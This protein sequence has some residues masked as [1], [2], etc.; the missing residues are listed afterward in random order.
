MKNFDPQL[1]FHQMISIINPNKKPEIKA[2]SS[3][4]SI[5]VDFFAEGGNMVYGLQNNIAFK[6]SEANGKGL[7]AKGFIVSG[8]DTAA[9]FSTEK[10]GMGSFSFIPEKGKK[11]RAIVIYNQ[12]NII[13]DLPV[14][15]DSGW[16]THTTN[17]AGKV[18]VNVACNIPDAHKVHVLILTGNNITNAQSVSLVNGNAVYSIDEANLAD[19]ISQVTVFN[20]RRQPVCE[21]LYFKIP[22]NFLQIKTTGIQYEYA[23]RSKVDFKVFTG[24]NNSYP[25]NAN[26]SASAYLIDS[27]QPQQENNIVSYLWLSTGVKGMIESPSYYFD[28]A[29]ADAAKAADN[30]MLTQGWRRFQWNDVFENTMPA[31]RFLPEYEGHII[32]GK[33]FGRTG[34][35]QN[36][37]K[38]VSLSVPGKSFRFSNATSAD[39]GALLFNIDKFY[40]SRELVMQ[41]NIADSNYRLFIDNPFSDKFI[42]SNLP[43]LNLNPGEANAITLRSI[44]A[45]SQNVYQPAKQD[46]FSL[47][48]HYDTTAFYGF[49]FKTYYLDNYTRFPTMEEVMREYIKEVHVRKRDRSFY[50]EVFD[51]PDVSYFNTP[52]LTLD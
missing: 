51:E 14:I 42:Q 17:N 16:V 32:T 11:Y 9:S 33:I 10:F 26:L 12:Q 29:N 47:P 49:P 45:Q 22:H 48:S 13:K 27:L 35:M 8:K 23:E 31:F 4:D 34:S 37:G 6:I 39:D 46:N 50:Y 15:Y 28:T 30:L 7:S 5:Y 36:S 40:G 41:T 20:E 2:T 38:R 1:Y 25:A 21:R 19:G 43:F 24:N 3:A 52:P 44:R 18:L